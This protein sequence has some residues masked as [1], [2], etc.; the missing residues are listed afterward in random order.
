VGMLLAQQ[1]AAGERRIIG[2]LT[3]VRGFLA[4]GVNGHEVPGWSSG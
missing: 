4:F 3:A 2:I 1:H